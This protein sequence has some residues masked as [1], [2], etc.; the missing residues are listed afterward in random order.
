MFK[1]EASIS[2][3]SH[4]LTTSNLTLD[5]S[6]SKGKELSYSWKVT[7]NADKV[8]LENSQSNKASIRLKS[9]PQSDF[10]VE[11]ELTVTDNGKKY[12][13]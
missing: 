11:V 9:A 8:T 3:P 6:G 10:E 7:K 5:G 1:P 4:T 13:H 2:A 12:K